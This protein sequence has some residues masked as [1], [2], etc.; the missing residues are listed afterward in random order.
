MTSDEIEHPWNR[1]Q[2]LLNVPIYQLSVLTKE[3]HDS[4]PHA[5]IPI[6]DR[7]MS[8]L[9]TEFWD[10]CFSQ[11]EIRTAFEQAIADLSRYAAGEEI[12]A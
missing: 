8:T 2:D 12:R 3:L 9:A 7:A 11:T 4:D 1:Q 6:L 10:C 5:D